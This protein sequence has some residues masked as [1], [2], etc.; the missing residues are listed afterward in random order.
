MYLWSYNSSF[1]CPSILIASYESSSTSLFV[2][3]E[4]HLSIDWYLITFIGCGQGCHDGFKV[5]F[6]VSNGTFS[7]VSCATNW[8]RLASMIAK[9]L[10]INAMRMRRKSTER[11]CFCC[12]RLVRGSR[13][14][15]SVFSL[16]LLRCD[17]EN[18]LFPCGPLQG[19]LWTFNPTSLPH[20]TKYCTLLVWNLLFTEYVKL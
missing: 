20:T 9:L 10:I 8:C 14:S 5:R 17:D 4:Q 7:Y 15:P 2:F 19:G 18:S 11:E 1:R 3:I 16:S 6:R 12:H 13:V